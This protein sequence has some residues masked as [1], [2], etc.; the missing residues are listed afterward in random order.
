ML[1]A[2]LLPVLLMSICA[3]QQLEYWPIDERGK[4]LVRLRVL[5]Y[6]VC[7]VLMLVGHHHPVFDE[8]KSF[9]GFPEPLPS[10]LLVGA[11]FSG[12]LALLLFRLKGKLQKFKDDE[13]TNVFTSSASSRRMDGYSFLISILVS[14]AVGV[15]ALLVALLVNI[16]TKALPACVLGAVSLAEVYHRRSWSP[17]PYLMLILIA[18][19]TISIVSDSFVS[20]TIYYVR[21]D[22]HWMNT[23]LSM[24]QFC[25]GF[26]CILILSVV[27]PVFSV[28]PDDRK[29]SSL[30]P[31]S[32]SSPLTSS[33]HSK[34]LMSDSIGFAIVEYLIGFVALLFAATE[35]MIREQVSSVQFI[36]YIDFGLHSSMFFF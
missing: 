27:I 3:T 18:M 6:A 33:S 24:K 2:V 28:Q 30:L 10:V 20:N 7:G 9:S 32:A 23:Q 31:S 1:V 35:L 11:A 8:I 29:S 15:S 12:V 36:H 17:I 25:R 13:D 4:V 16:P 26:S 5:I 14:G 21:Y 19:I 34:E 22:F